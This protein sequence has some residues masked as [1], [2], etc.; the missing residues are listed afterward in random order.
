MLMKQNELVLVFND[1]KKL[2]CQTNASMLQLARGRWIKNSG[3]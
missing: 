3:P 2:S 1:L